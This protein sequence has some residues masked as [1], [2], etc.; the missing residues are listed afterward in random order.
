MSK[1]LLATGAAS[2]LLASTIVACA[3]LAPS[4][5]DSSEYSKPVHEHIVQADAQANDDDSSPHHEPLENGYYFDTTHFRIHYMLEGEAAVDAADS[6][7]DG[8]PDYIEL[9][10]ETL[11]YVRDVSINKFGWAAPPPDGD[12]GGNAL[13]DVYLEN[14]FENEEEDAAGYVV[15]LEPESIVG[16]NP[17][18]PDV[19][20]TNASISFM[21][22][23]KSYGG[24]SIENKE[25]LQELQ[26]I[27]A[28]E[29]LHSIQFG[30]DGEE[31][32]EWL[33]E[34]SA[35][36]MM[37]EVYPENNSA[38]LWEAY[39]SPDF[40]PDA[41]DTD[42]YGQWLFFRFISERY[43]HDTVKAVWEIA[44]TQDGYQAI[45]TALQS[46]GTT[47]EEVIRGYRLAMLLNNFEKG[48]TYPTV[49]LEGEVTNH[50]K[51]TDGVD[52][53]GAD[54]MEL[55]GN[56]PL[57]VRLDATGLEGRVIG[58]RE[59]QASV[60]PMVQNSVTVDGSTFDYLY[61]I[62]QNAEWRNAADD[63]PWLSYQITITPGSDVA[64][65]TQVIDAPNFKAPQVSKRGDYLESIEDEEWDEER[66]ER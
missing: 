49:R 61:L 23:D 8:T 58:I 60:F 63:E 47:L 46:V 54:Y 31:S 4:A 15:S 64:V 11:D 5:E 33:W 59:G 27:A 22:L 36:W 26:S 57:M 10:G 65:P 56:G 29:Y 12:L 55:V 18:T 42:W 39:E 17:N 6:D 38:D 9:V 37:E 53:L 7:R 43:G 28:H 30:Y 3:S 13:Y 48:S 14:L 1:S 16:D 51:P 32:A 66:T 45:D 19:V 35:E 44:R 25:A 62:V 20:E 24:A 50:F 41:E 21:A 52:A 2:V 34:A 40:A